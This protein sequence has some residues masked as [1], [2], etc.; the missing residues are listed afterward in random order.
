MKLFDEHRMFKSTSDAAD[1]K[2]NGT[3]D[4]G[5]RDPEGDR[6]HQLVLLCAVLYD[7]DHA[8]IR[9]RQRLWI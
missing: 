4:E 2:E 8:R 9:A 6:A 5:G 3:Y 7:G 1:H